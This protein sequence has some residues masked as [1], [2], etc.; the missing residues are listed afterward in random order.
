MIIPKND[1][2]KFKLGV[3]KNKIKYCIIE[4]INETKTNICVSI[5]IGN[6]MNPLIQIIKVTFAHFLYKYVIYG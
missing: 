3:L 6:I 1:K 2:R 5:K 4:D